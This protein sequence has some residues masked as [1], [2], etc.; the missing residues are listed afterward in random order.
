[1]DAA[2]TGSAAAAPNA[3]MMP[4][5]AAHQLIVEPMVEP[6]SE[7]V[8]E[9]RAQ[10]LLSES[11]F[12]CHTLQAGGTTIRILP[13]G[14]IYSIDRDV[15]YPTPAVVFVDERLDFFCTPA[16]VLHSPLGD[17][18]DAVAERCTSGD[19]GSSSPS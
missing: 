16:V 11:H 6:A 3:P 18:G 1:M 13:S 9:V 14:C 8:G 2:Q 7:P 5:A 15:A 4:T 10:L 12:R 19:G 17:D